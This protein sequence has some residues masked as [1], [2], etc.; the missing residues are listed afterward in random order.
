LDFTKE[1]SEMLL[2]MLQNRHPIYVIMKDWKNQIFES[3]SENLRKEGFT[4]D[5]IRKVAQ[6]VWVAFDML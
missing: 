2:K 5:Q 6:A 4:D 3:M 1:N